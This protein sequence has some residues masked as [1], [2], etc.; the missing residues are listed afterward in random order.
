MI[1]LESLLKE[2][3]KDSP[4]DNENL[5]AESLRSANLHS[6]YLQILSGLKAGL[7]KRQ[8]KLDKLK[9]AK[10]R[11][12]SGK[13][14]QQEMDD[15]KWEYDPFK[16]GSKPMKSELD[17]WIGADDEIQLVKEEVETYKI[18]I[19]AALDIVNHVNWRHQSIRNAIDWAKF[20]AGG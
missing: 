11:W 2:W 6:K 15:R 5:H 13:M 12:L 14:T 17:D 16:G 18:M 3:E 1:T 7:M 10:K 8:M 4:I 19:E 9:L 20:Q